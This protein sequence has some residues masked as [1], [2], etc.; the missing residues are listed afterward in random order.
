MADLM[1]PSA[2]GVGNHVLNLLLRKLA[3]QGGQPPGM[4]LAADRG[5]LPARLEAPEPKGLGQVEPQWQT[6]ATMPPPPPVGGGFSL[7]GGGQLHIPL[8]QAW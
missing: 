8:G 1:G 7:R 4:G 2:A 6:L 3:A 5:G